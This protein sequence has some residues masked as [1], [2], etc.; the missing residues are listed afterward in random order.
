MEPILKG[1]F[2]MKK[3][4]LKFGGFFSFFVTLSFSLWCSLLR[5]LFHSPLKPLHLLVLPLVTLIVLLVCL[6]SFFL[7][8]FSLLI[9]FFHFP[10]LLFIFHFLFRLGRRTMGRRSCSGGCVDQQMAELPLKRREESF[11]FVSEVPL[12]LFDIFFC[13]A[14]LVFKI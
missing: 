14:H 4:K 9:H 10:F 13:F 12:F 5:R 6:L 7:F 3:P 11:T 8:S 1:K 2:G